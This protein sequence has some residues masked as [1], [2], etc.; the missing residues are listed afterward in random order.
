MTQKLVS[1]LNVRV[2][3]C[4]SGKDKTSRLQEPFIGGFIL[5]LLNWTS[6]LSLTYSNVK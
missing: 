2:N 5:S 3:L 1:S 6:F 4:V